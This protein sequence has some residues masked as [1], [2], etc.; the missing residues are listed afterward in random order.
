MKVLLFAFD[1]NADNPYLPHLFDGNCV[2]Y[3]GTHD[4][5]TVAGYC[6]GLST[7]ELILFRSQIAAEMQRLELN[8]PIGDKPEEMSNAIVH[9][10]LASKAR[11]AVVPVQ[12]ILGLDNE[13]RM[14]TPGKAYGN[15]RF[16]LNCLPAGKHMR[17]LQKMIK[18][19]GRII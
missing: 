15:W 4:N 19:Y 1:S 7:E 14:N 9:L 11:L 10:C 17:R 13:S 6:K 16:R 2:C 5:D 8:V 18:I 3:T 12:D